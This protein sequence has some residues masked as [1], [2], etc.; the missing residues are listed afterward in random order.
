MKLALVSLALASTAAF[1]PGA[2]SP[3]APLRVAS[4]EAPPAVSAPGRA[5][6]AANSHAVA[7]AWHPST[8]AEEGLLRALQPLPPGAFDAGPTAVCAAAAAGLRGTS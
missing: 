4:V 8:W 6:D 2:R 1:A 5:F 7:A 3:S